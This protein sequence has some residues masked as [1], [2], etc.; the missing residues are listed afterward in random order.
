MDDLIS[1][2]VPVYNVENYLGTCI[3]SILAQTYRTLEIILV[4][5]GSTDASESIMKKYALSDERIYC[6]SQ[7]N[8]G[9]SAARNRG[10]KAAKG[11]Y[12]V[13]ADADDFMESDMIASLYQMMEQQ[14][15]VTAC[16]YYCV[17]GQ[18]E[19]LPQNVPFKEEFPGEGIYDEK[20]FWKMYFEKSCIYPVVAWN[21][22][23]CRNILTGLAF[24]EGKYHEDEFFINLLW[25]NQFL[26]KCTPRKL[27][28]YRI[29]E[30]SITSKISAERILD[31]MEAFTE[32]LGYFADRRMYDE[33]FLMFDR[34]LVI[35]QGLIQ[36]E[37]EEGKKCITDLIHRFQ[38]TVVR[39]V[40]FPVGFRLR[41][42]AIVFGFFGRHY[43]A[44]RAVCFRVKANSPG[45]N[46]D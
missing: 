45:S 6:I 34:M 12:V 14:V 11:E 16:G 41:A 9:L 33:F 28:D 24:P 37:K 46:G 25:R 3:E 18:G 26:I 10:L 42:K 7:E 21:K 15:S 38:R 27:Y 32:R 43:F 35:L 17:D 31:Q 5:D 1:V 39:A 29:R 2:I 19:K 4:N 13:F 8:G 44:I 40:F 20:A 22:L 30:N 36:M 23:F